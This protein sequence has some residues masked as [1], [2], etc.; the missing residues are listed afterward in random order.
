MEIL[1]AGG[2]GR[3]MDALI[4]KFRKEGHRVYIL[5]GTRYRNAP[6]KKVFEKYYF[7]YDSEVLGEIFES[8]N[9]DVTIFL[10]AYDTNF[11]WNK[12][13]EREAVRFQAGVMNMLISFSK[14]QK[15]RFVYISSEEVYSGNYPEDISEE[16]PPTPSNT[17]AMAIAQGEQLCM[18]YAEN[19]GKD[20]VILR[21]DHIY[22]TPKNRNEVRDPCSRMCLEAIL[23]G[24]L[25]IFSYQLFSLLHEADAVEFIFRVVNSRQ[26]KYTVYNLSTSAQF[27]STE[28]AEIIAEHTETTVIT[29]NVDISKPYR[30]ILSGNRYNSEF[31]FSFFHDIKGTVKE[32]IEVMKADPDSFRAE[33][34]KKKTLLGYLSDR[35]V[36][37]FWAL[38][39]FI[40]NMIAFIPFFMLNNRAVGSQYFQNLDFYLLYVL[41]FAIVYGQQQAV[42]SGVLATAGYCFR[43]M[44]DRTGFEVMLD[45]N[46]Y[47]WIAQLFILGMVVGFMKDQLRIV[48]GEDEQ[49]MDY[50]MGLLGDI[51]DINDSNV[52]LKNVFETQI[53]NQNDSIGRLYEVIS[54]L[55]QYSPEEVLFYAAD[56]LSRIIGSPDVAIYNV[57]NHSYARLF[58]ATSPKARVLGNSIKYTELGILYEELMAKKV[59]INKSMNQDYPLMANAVYSENQMEIII[60]IWGIPWERMTLSEANMLTVVSYLIQNAVLRASRYLEALEYKRY[61][62][63]THILDAEAFTALVQ[64]FSK[65]KEKGLTECT[66]LLVEYGDMTLR[67]AG[68][69][70]VKKLRQTDIAGTLSDGNLYLILSN[71]NIE[72]ASYVISRLQ[73]C[74][75]E[76]EL[77]EELAA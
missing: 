50:L 18:A 9:P 22:N 39:P 70:F 26:H 75:M 6:Y 41:L 44:Y 53:V 47:V 3:L 36:S 28:I 37:T 57:S 21:G 10:G 58:A 11:V 72:T 46:T 59:F 69:V 13:C 27:S 20:I 2:S 14:M 76:C 17:K 51:E 48:K 42:F 30:K 67:E 68:D 19:M 25:E 54:S 38:L 34:G 71:T 77:R 43:Q 32:N 31:G 66:F 24:T 5:T 64:A 40:E 60:M 1:L 62:E 52:R 8:V 7:S 16:E 74:G 23:T 29:S 4:D 12:D 45:Y 35:A 63:G 56:V 33:G 15:G 55:E 61:V 49:E 65:A 73:E